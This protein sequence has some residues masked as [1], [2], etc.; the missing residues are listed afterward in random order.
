MIE[1]SKAAHT[2]TGD[3]VSTCQKKAVCDV[4]G[5][6]YGDFADHDWNTFWEKDET[7]HWYKCNTEECA[8]KKDF[9]A[10]T[11]DHQGGATEEY[12]IKCTA[13]GWIIEQQLGHT[14]I[15][16]KE[17]AQEQY[18]ASKA[19]CNEP[20]KYY[21]SCVCG[22]ASTEIFEYGTANGHTEGATW[23]K[24][25]THHWHI[26]TTAGCGAII[27][28]SKVAHTPDHKGGATEEYAIKCTGCGYVMEAQ[29]KH[30]HVFNKKLATG[31]YLAS[32]ATCTEPAKYY[33][34]CGC[35]MKGTATFTSGKALG[36]I[37]GT[38]WEKDATGHW[39]ICTAA[40]CGAIIDTSKAAHT[41]DRDAA[42]ETD[43]IKCSVCGYVIAPALGHTHT[44]GADWKSDRD[45]HWNECAC[46]NK[47][48][49]AAHKDNSNDGKCDTC[50]YNVGLPADPD[51][52]ETDG[53]GMMYLW[54]ILIC[55]GVIGAVAATILIKKKSAK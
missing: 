10:H 38:A 34:S 7:G 17:V 50:G 45:N 37:A 55:V 9:A 32:R 51:N 20:A 35:G 43:P 31:Q 11:P 6:T 33:I 26:C 2:S 36:H 40:G 14:H 15:F 54:I 16:D 1:S 23:Q 30:T 39:H 46:G 48:N 24:N 44:H 13:C 27:D 8:E 42:T 5:V 41:P 29:L 28:A 22:Q 52:S 12:P 21:I 3:N 4:C 19:S 18:L 53:N 49:T 25:A 47:A